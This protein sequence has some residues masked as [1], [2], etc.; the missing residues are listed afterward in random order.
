MHSR[1]EPILFLI[2]FNNCLE[3]DTRIYHKMGKPATREKLDQIRGAASESLRM[4]ARMN[5][6]EKAEWRLQRKK[7]KAAAAR[8]RYHAKKERLKQ[9][10]EELITPSAESCDPAL[11]STTE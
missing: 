6:E 9:E 5:D 2:N 7:E 1:S 8:Q 3:K 11:L 10:K 4:L